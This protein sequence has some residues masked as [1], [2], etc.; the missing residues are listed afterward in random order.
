MDPVALRVASRRFWL[1]RLGKE[2]PTEEAR[3]KYLKEHPKA[4][5]K[6]HRVNKDKKE[7]VEVD[8]SDVHP[9]DDN[10]DTIKKLREQRQREQA[11]LR[12]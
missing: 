6:K 11:K 7:K 5:P 1:E 3:E 8:M 4:D 10:Y 2:F 9:T 12:R